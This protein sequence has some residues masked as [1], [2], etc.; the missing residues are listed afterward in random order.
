[1]IGC[2]EPLVA[3]GSK[4]RTANVRSSR[5]VLFQVKFDKMDSIT[6]F[7]YAIVISQRDTESVLLNRLKELGEE[8]RRPVKVV[9]MEERLVDV[10]GKNAKMKV[11]EVRF[12]N[13]ETVLAKYVVGAD[14]SRSTIR[15]LAGIRFLTIN[16]FRQGIVPD[17]LDGDSP[18]LDR[19]A[20][21]LCLVDIR[22]SNVPEPLT[23]GINLFFSKYLMGWVALKD[24]SYRLV[25]SVPPGTDVP[26]DPSLQFVQDIVN[27]RGLEGS[28]A[29]VEE[30]VWASRFRVRSR[31]AHRFYVPADELPAP[32][33]SSMDKQSLATP[34]DSPP[35]PTASSI[36]DE[37]AFIIKGGVVLAGDAAHVHSPAGG[38]GMNLGIRDA[39]IL[40]KA[41][42]EDLKG[43]QNAL[44]EYQVDRQ[45]LAAKVIEMTDK[46][47]WGFL[48][49]GWQAKIRDFLG[50][51]LGRTPWF[52]RMAAMRL[53]GMKLEKSFD[54][55]INQV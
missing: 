48:R 32:S 54:Y 20:H 23:S 40:A 3:L 36:Q 46:M 17:L 53:S 24:G 27:E 12:E 4:I 49:T 16:Q 47:M 6:K 9:G 2:A 52:G 39:I 31:I 11:R 45:Q 35:A 33:K 50:W 51:C 8:V 14:G 29:K 10:D 21:S 18:D 25:C 37:P 43:D 7:P 5:R 28:G 41:I 26:K 19:S 42:Q 15:N 38:Q 1:M 30:V 34:P 55:K 22:L 44:R 13:G